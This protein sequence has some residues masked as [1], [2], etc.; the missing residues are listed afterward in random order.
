MK[1]KHGIS[2]VSLMTA[3]LIMIL[4]I[5]TATI[6]M[7]QVYQNIS[8]EMFASELES[9]QLA[10]H[11]YYT[12]HEQYP[13]TSE[14]YILDLSVLSTQSLTQFQ[15]EAIENNQIILSKID[16]AKAG[17]TELKY[18]KGNSE[19]DYYAL[20]ITTGKVYYLEG[21]EIDGEK[22]YTL[23]EQVEKWAKNTVNET[24]EMIV[25]VP[26]ETDWTNQDV[27]V[28]IKIP[29]KYTDIMVM[30]Y[31]TYE[32]VEGEYVYLVKKSSNGTIKVSYQDGKKNCETSYE[33]K[34]I[35]KIKPTLTVSEHITLSDAYNAEIFGYYTI[36]ELYD[37]DS[38]IKC[39]KYDYGKIEENISSYF[40]NHGTDITGN[41]IPIVRGNEYITVYVE[42]NASNMT[43]LYIK[44]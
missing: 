41:K 38:G 34:N 43:V 37:H 44:I 16:Y 14:N 2:L 33:I 32:Q 10:V 19:K 31:A 3:L 36:E 24:D 8:K 6:S 7:K 13:I 9:L 23:T 18:G 22:Y 15:D 12:V 35:D 17:Y 28:K 4:I 30:E 42:D 27:S 20:S 39:V 11:S 21:L 25:F 26:D 1:S 5:T 29:Q 40:S